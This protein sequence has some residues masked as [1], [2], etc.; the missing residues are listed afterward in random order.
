MAAHVR[1]LHF[2]F[3]SSR[4]LPSFKRIFVLGRQSVRDSAHIP[5]ISRRGDDADAPG[6]SCHFVLRIA[7]I[8]RQ[9]CDV[10][11][12]GA[13]ATMQQFPPVCL[14]SRLLWLLEHSKVTRLPCFLIL[15]ALKMNT[16]PNFSFSRALMRGEKKKTKHVL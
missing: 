15:M 4:P 13:V 3:L 2:L 9:K 1:K 7:V 12:L 16:P 14:Q 10:R 5:V 8:R 6:D 11:T